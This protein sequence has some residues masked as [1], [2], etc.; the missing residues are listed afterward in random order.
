MGL[1]TV[2][3][4]YKKDACDYYV[5]PEEAE[6]V[7]RIFSEYISGKTMKSIGD[8]LTSEN[9]VY[10]EKKTIWTKNA[11][12]RI[13]E[14]EHYTGDCNYPEIISKAIFIEANEKRIRKGGKHDIQEPYIKY[15]KN[16]I[17]CDECGNRFTRYKNYTG[18][19]ERWK[20]LHGCKTIKLLDDA[21]LFNKINSIINR[22][23][24]NP[25]LLRHENS[26]ESGFE[27]SLDLIKEEREVTRLIE[28]KS[29]NFELIKRAVFELKEKTFDKCKTNYAEG[30]T[31]KLIDFFKSLDL[32][33]DLDLFLLDKIA[34]SIRINKFG[35]V[36]IE[37][38]NKR[39][40][41]ER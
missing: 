4:G 32:Q 8:E 38:I 10:Y 3:Y 41:S 35:Q 15:L 40:V 29:S 18:H 21:S 25:E 14:N 22:A 39:I 37:F 1:R 33:G 7:K 16:K 26:I 6:I 5:H 2:L 19:G 36:S 28:Q 20:C 9:I 31:D 13:L 27:L 11:I 23:I 12:C 30:I 17:V 24:I 34:K